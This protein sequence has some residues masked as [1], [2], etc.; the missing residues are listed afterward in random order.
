MT[1][2]LRCVPCAI[3]GKRNAAPFTVSGT[4]LC[5][6]HLK[7]FADQFQYGGPEGAVRLALRGEL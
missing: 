4:T 7:S 2:D 5:G 3:Q 6:D 1:N